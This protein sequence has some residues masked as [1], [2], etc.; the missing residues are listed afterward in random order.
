MS[1]MAYKMAAIKTKSAISHHPDQIEVREVFV[2]KCTAW[3]RRNCLLYYQM[4]FAVVFTKH[5]SNIQICHE[6]EPYMQVS[7]MITGLRHNYVL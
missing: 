4:P 5:L 1:K 7:A 6:H 3:G 2:Y